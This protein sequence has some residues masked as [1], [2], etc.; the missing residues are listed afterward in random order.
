MEIDDFTRK[1]IKKYM[2]NSFDEMLNNPKQK[3]QDFAG[4]AYC[5]AL[6]MLQIL[7]IEIDRITKNFD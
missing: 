4:G 5:G 1:R 2:D 7:N 6:K 3:V